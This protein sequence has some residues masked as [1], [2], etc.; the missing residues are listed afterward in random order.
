MPKGQEAQ[1]SHANDQQLLNNSNGSN[2]D[3]SETK[4]RLSFLSSPA[5]ANEKVSIVRAAGTFF[6][7]NGDDENEIDG[8][9]SNLKRKYKEVDASKKCQ[10]PNCKEMS[11]QHLHCDECDKVKKFLIYTKSFEMIKKNQL[12]AFFRF[13]RTMQHFYFIQCNIKQMNLRRITAKT[14]P[15]ISNRTRCSIWTHL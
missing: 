8:N 15:T 13:S 5:S 6:P 7:R 12:N 9:I 3:D 4:S 1:A 10:V 2:S 11:V 14:F